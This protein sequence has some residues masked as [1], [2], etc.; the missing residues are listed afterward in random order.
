[1]I[2]G[3]R[4]VRPRLG[5]PDFRHEGH[6][7]F[8]IGDSF[9]MHVLGPVWDGDA[10]D[11]EPIGIRCPNREFDRLRFS[12][13]RG[14]LQNRGQGSQLPVIMD[15]DGDTDLAL[16]APRQSNPQMSQRCSRGNVTVHTDGQR[17]PF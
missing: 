7:D 8:R 3:N 13:I 1:M 10:L 4:E 14:Q 2:R 11:V 9:V 6:P 5:I 12:G 17:S 15:C 16:G